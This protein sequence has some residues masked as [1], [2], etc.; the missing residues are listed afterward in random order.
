MLMNEHTVRIFTSLNKNHMHSLIHNYIAHQEAETRIHGENSEWILT[1][2][3]FL[4][5]QLVKNLPAILPVMQETLVQFLSQKDP[6][7]K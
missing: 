3:G 7:E 6:L 4:L 1:C 2:K 5:S